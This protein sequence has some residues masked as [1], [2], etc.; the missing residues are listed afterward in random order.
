M[1]KNITKFYINKNNVYNELYIFCLDY[2]FLQLISFNKDNY[3]AILD[4]SEFLSQQ[5]FTEHLSTNFSEIEIQE[6]INNKTQIY[7]IN[8][9]IYRDDTIE[10]I[11]YKFLKFYNIINGEN[12]KSFEEVYLYTLIQERFN[13]L[14]IF[15]H[16]LSFQEKTDIVKYNDIINYFT[17][18]NDVTRIIN[19]LE[20]KLYYTF[21]DILKLNLD[22]EYIY[23]KIGHTI[24]KTNYEYLFITNIFNINNLSSSL[25]KLDNNSISTQNSDLLIDYS[26]VFNDFYIIFF[27][28][29]V[30]YTE[31]NSINLET[32]IKLYYPFLYYK[33][34]EN[35][36]SFTKAKPD[37]INKTK[38]T[39][40]SSNFKNTNSV[41]ELLHKVYNNDQQLNYNYFGI[42]S[43]NLN[44][45]LDLDI[46]IPLDIIFK[47][48][49]STQH[50]PLI[51]Y[52]P[53]K[54]QENIYRIYC[55][56]ISD[57]NDK[58]PYLSNSAI[59]KTNKLIGKTNRVALVITNQEQFY[60]EFD[61]EGIINVKIEYNTTSDLITL[62][63]LLIDNINPI[64]ENINNILSNTI[65]KITPISSL[66]Q[67]NIEIIN[68]N[69]VI[70]IN[71]CN[72]N[73]FNQNK[74]LVACL[75]NII[76]NNKEK[77]NREI[78]MQ[79]KHVS[80]YNKMN[81]LDAFILQLI[82]NKSSEQDILE[83]IQDSFELDEADSKKKF[84]EFISHLE[85]ETQENN[86]K[87]LRIKNNPGFYTKLYNEKFSNNIIIDING[88]NNISYLEFLPIYFDSIIKIINQKITSQEKSLIS[89]LGKTTTSA[90]DK[91]LHVDIKQKTDIVDMNKTKTSLD[92]DSLL[93]DNK[94]T[95]INLLLDDSDSDTSNK[96]NTSS[97]SDNEYLKDI[98][99]DESDNEEF[100]VDDKVEDEQDN[101][102]K[103]QDN[104]DE[105]PAS[106]DEEPDK[107]DEE[108]PVEQEVEQEQPVKQQQDHDIEEEQQTVKPEDDID[109]TGMNLHHNPILKRLETREPL[110]F[111][112]KDNP[113][114]KGFSR[115]CPTNAKRQPVILTQQEKDRID[116]D[117]SGS[118]THAFQYGTKPD[119]KYWYICPRYWDLKRNVSLTHEQVMSGKYGKI[120]PD[121]IKKIPPGYNIYEFTSDKHYD[122]KKQYIDHA[123]GFLKSQY[124][125]KEGFCLPCCFKDWDSKKAEENR[126]KCIDNT[127]IE[128]ENETD[129]YEYVQGI[130]KFPLEPKRIGFLPLNV[131]YF[132][133]HDNQKCVNVKTNM[134]LTEHS[135][136]LRYGVTTSANQSFIS[137]IA[138]LYGSLI[139]NRDIDNKTMKQIII[140][141]L[142]LDLFISLN[143]GNLIQIF[144][145]RDV[146]TIDSTDI[147]SH[148][149][150]LFYKSIKVD[151][152]N[153]LTLFKTA[154][155]SMSNF[156][157]YL[158]RDD[159][160][161]DYS[162]LW[163]IICKKN[164][165]L[166]KDGVN[167]VILEETD[168]DITSNVNVI[169]PQQ[170]YSQEN[171]D[172]DKQ[173]LILIKKDNIFEPIYRVNN[174][175]IKYQ[176]F[177][178]FNFNI[179]NNNLKDFKKILNII[180]FHI[181]RYCR[182]ERD[183]SSQHKDKKITE[184]T[185]NLNLE[186]VVTILLRLS[187]KISF[188]IMNY[189][190]KI[191]GVVASRN[192]LL[193]GKNGFIPCYPSSIYR[194][195][196][197][198]I[199]FMDDYSDNYYNNY[200][201]TITIL[202]YVYNNS[203]N[204]INVKPIIKVM[205]DSLVVGV[206]TNSNQFVMLEE[207]ELNIEDDELIVLEDT[208]LLEID[209][210][211]QTGERRYNDR[212]SITQ[213][214]YL[215]TN[216]YNI[217]KLTIRKILLDYKNI[218]V[219][220]R[221]E[222]IVNN[223]SITYYDKV[224]SLIK[225]I[226]ELCSNY[227]LFSEY[228][229]KV[230]ERITNITTCMDSDESSVNKKDWCITRVIGKQKLGVLIIPKYNLIN[231]K[232]NDIIY[233]SRFC[234]Q[235]VRNTI[236]QTSIFSREQYYDVNNINYNLGNDEIII[237]ENLL[238]K[239]FFN[240]RLNVNVSNY[241]NYDM[242]S[243]KKSSIPLNFK[244]IDKSQSIFEVSKKENN[245]KMKIK[246]ESQALQPDT[247]SSSDSS[248]TIC[249]LQRNLVR[250]INLKKVFTN[251]LYE[252]HS[253]INSKREC[254]FKIVQQLCSDNN[255]KDVEVNS[256]KK[257]LVQLYSSLNINTQKF[258]K[259][260]N[261]QKH[262][263]Y[264][265]VKTLDPNKVDLETLII[266][267]NY[268][269]TMID[270]YL[271]TKHY[272]I[273]VIFIST[274]YIPIYSKFHKEVYNF[275]IGY[276]TPKSENF[277]FIKINSHY[278][279][280]KPD[281]LSNHKLLCFKEKYLFN[282]DDL[283][284]HD[285]TSTNIK[286]LL[287][288]NRDYYREYIDKYLV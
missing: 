237:Y 244:N 126:A 65:K 6:I 195:I 223:I 277:Y 39:L 22:N 216:F 260:I 11:K 121:N 212:D 49:K 33:K 40:E 5:L 64:I 265:D 196:E 20:K 206:I 242:I 26:T 269:L 57:Q 255:I 35:L 279:R 180:R 184:F 148:K 136:L 240:K 188:Q 94:E 72:L 208:N 156:S 68:I 96:S 116:K 177:K 274:T 62:N 201:D 45:H 21:D 264:P 199:K 147:E 23:R 249:A 81:A 103:E 275:L 142:D 246:L 19:Q 117:Y 230:L 146:T 241:T 82:K 71:N 88:I 3:Y 27:T 261:I 165:K 193:N 92:I 140:D 166:F 102:D 284:D 250:E 124:N 155:N 228:N 219:K 77:L 74:Q 172:I 106:D 129:F 1:N 34:I 55:P 75:F 190:G 160:A 138:D 145:S 151:D 95:P 272:K 179:G 137:C 231:K 256:I 282:L 259:H 158:L 18:F 225:I 226:R 73:Q 107:D 222:S 209:K 50:I 135:C 52:N 15:K 252:L 118:Y 232:D 233:Y 114:F 262:N 268:Y 125:T 287:E 63:K 270:I 169:C 100:G 104:D 131:Q 154:I 175:K 174:S 44:I 163:D 36:I 183:N 214:I 239:E 9:N 286:L 159:I 132:L 200:K 29:A 197:I 194:D 51:K 61:S 53:G 153:Q 31:K 139:L 84:I 149:T 4:N 211:I 17:N 220:Q 235:L 48:I 202:D 266:S 276:S 185:V 161:I 224:E 127:K 247:T 8:S 67:N 120:I 218:T 7:L 25:N 182:I 122:A 253:D 47:I 10:T 80:N 28:D 280:Y 170:N 171:I 42:K 70:N 90:N 281:Q 89:Y 168:S 99:F 13:P 189:N 105:E 141:S 187:F 198:P 12:N 285:N 16:L 176:I 24:N 78:I 130:D 258:I 143:N 150:S 101:Y 46:S 248:P 257:L 157:K 162:Y 115:I 236:L 243:K 278:T 238:N 273:P 54:N 267:E 87:Y 144:K 108:Q 56:N 41:I 85:L 167:L 251:E 30:E 254:S 263:L 112:Q 109:V 128:T 229:D 178:T 181:N 221:I 59:L 14:K 203:N 207:P 66:L 234:D 186:N 191:I 98:L 43:I 133:Q 119:N 86:Y 79:Y 111:L 2:K 204:K 58:I 271:I 110:L 213:S 192:N 91:Q 210:K 37:L 38:K 288:N 205:E 69:Y 283:T 60:I 93:D 83:K 152:N 123:P 32:I 245:T 227:F 76:E 97:N 164:E 173:C 217:F 215:E 134:L 113:N